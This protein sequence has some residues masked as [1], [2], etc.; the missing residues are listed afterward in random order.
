MQVISTLTNEWRNPV[1][2]LNTARRPKQGVWLPGLKLV[3]GDGEYNDVL[4]FFGMVLNGLYNVVVETV[5]DEEGEIK[6]NVTQLLIQ[7]EL[8]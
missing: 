3:L 5:V 6:T 2:N 8:A 7:S 4:A 1:L